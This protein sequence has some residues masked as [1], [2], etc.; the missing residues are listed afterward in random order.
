MARMSAEKERAAAERTLKEAVTAVE[1]QGAKDVAAE[2]AR[3]QEVR[4]S[5]LCVRVVPFT[6]TPSSVLG[7]SAF[8]HG[9]FLPVTACS[10]WRRTGPDS[11]SGQ[12]RR[13]SS[14]STALPTRK[15]RQS[16]P[17]P[18]CFWNCS[19]FCTHLSCVLTADHHTL[20][21]DRRS[22]LRRSRG[23]RKRSPR[24]RPRSRT[25]S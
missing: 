14:F 16:R 8:P 2:A 17:R 12:R 22:S 7:A 15:R 6:H 5:G 1:A 10:A 9:V 24:R 3:W 25:Q 20:A 21:V 23:C 19:S 18:R 4:H 13:S 11:S